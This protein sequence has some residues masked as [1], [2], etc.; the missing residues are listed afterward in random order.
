MLILF[1]LVF[2]VQSLEKQ[3][4]HELDLRWFTAYVI[5]DDPLV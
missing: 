2:P 5:E 4:N 3:V 1:L